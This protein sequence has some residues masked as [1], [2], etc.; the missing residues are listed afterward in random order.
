MSIAAA[1]PAPTAQDRASATLRAAILDGELR[2]GQRVNQE[3]WAEKAGV[4]LLSWRGGRC[5]AHLRLAR[6]HGEFKAAELER[7]RAFMPQI[8]L[9]ET[10]RYVQSKLP[11]AAAAP[12]SDVSDESEIWARRLSA[13]ERDIVSYLGLG[14]TNEQIAAACGSSPHT[15]RNQLSRA[16]AKL[17]VASRA[18][19]VSVLARRARRKPAR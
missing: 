17:G 14:Y 5:V 9:S 6:G 7:L 10:L 1:G 2:P 16:Y 19:A 3:T 12:T 4:S 8:Q 18:E 13:R 11:E 15:I